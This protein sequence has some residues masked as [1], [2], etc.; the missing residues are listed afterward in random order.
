[1]GPWRTVTVP[2]T[3]MMPAWRGV[4]RGRRAPKR[5]MS[6]GDMESDMNSMAQHAVANGYGKIEY[7]RAQP[8]ALSRRVSTTVSPR[9][10]AL[11][12][13]TTRGPG[14]GSGFGMNN[15]RLSPAPHSVKSPFAFGRRPGLPGARHG[16]LHALDPS[17]RARHLPRD[18]ARRGARPPARGR[19]GGRPGPP[20]PASRARPPSVQRPLR[21]RSRG[22][23][24]LRC[25]GSHRLQ[26][27]ARCQ[28]RPPRVAARLEAP[29][30]LRPHQRRHLSLLRP[31]PS[32]G[33]R[34]ARTAPGR[35][36]EAGRHDPP[37]AFRRLA[38]RGARGVDDVGRPPVDALM[39]ESPWDPAQYARFADER[40]RPFEDLLALVRPRPGM[41]VVDLGC[42]MG[43]LTRVVHERLGAGETVGIDSSPTMLARA[44]AVAGL[45]FERGAIE[46]F[47][48]ERAYDL[49]FSNSALHWVADHSALLARL[50][51]A[52]TDG[53]Q[54]A[55]QVPANFDHPSHTTAF[56][57]ARE[58]PFRTALGE[59]E[60]TAGV[61]VPE[62][63]AALLARLGFREQHVRLQV[64]D[65]WL[66]GRD[67]VVEWTKGT[68]LTDYKRRLGPELYERFVAR[69]RERLLPALDD[70]R[71]YFFAFKRI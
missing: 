34:R 17:A 37:H 51:A 55:F 29:P 64:Y 59:V 60:H 70:T 42:G 18:D 3:M 32:P 61:L 26:G 12:E 27:G 49:V 43:E 11:G 6:Y 52:L 28:L 46:H 30:H 58:E 36:R 63:Y 15:S 9:S 71:P 54:L 66:P 19:G 56:A 13:V 2:I 39:A 21:R 67:E 69:Y 45:R 22:A 41:R 57:V 10:D 62:A 33:T 48:A 23:R 7:L 5:S 1:M 16:C 47:A 20:A 35:A 14:G 68:L 8:I 65:H 40:R 53:G 44:V 38:R 24:H 4:K 25:L 31:R 50:C